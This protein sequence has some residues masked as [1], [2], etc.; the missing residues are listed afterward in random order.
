ML[1]RVV[2]CSLALAE[3]QLAVVVVAQ[4]DLGLAQIDEVIG[5]LVVLADVERVVG[6]H[7]Q[8]DPRAEDSVFAHLTGADEALDIPTRPNIGRTLSI[9]V[10]RDV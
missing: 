8:L 10:N 5:G 4:R 6:A 2:R 9:S 7:R 1:G 3:E